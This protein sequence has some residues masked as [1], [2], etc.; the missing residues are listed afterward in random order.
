MFTGDIFRDII[1]RSR[2]VKCI[3]GHQILKSVWFKVTKVLFHS[4]RFELEDGSGFTPAEQ[5][6]R[7]GIIEGDFFNVKF[8]SC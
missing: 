1:H 3:H 7:F 4:F 6:I 5:F 8:L 2:S